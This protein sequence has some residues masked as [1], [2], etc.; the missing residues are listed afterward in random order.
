MHYAL[1]TPASSNHLPP[2]EWSKFFMPE[3][4][5]LNEQDLKMTYSELK[6]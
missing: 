5:V 1:Y 6:V 3:L 2:K 4:L